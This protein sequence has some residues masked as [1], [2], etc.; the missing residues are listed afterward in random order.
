MTTGQYGGLSI[1]LTYCAV[2]N[3]TDRAIRVIANIVAK[4]EVEYFIDKIELIPSDAGR[5]EFLVNGD[6]LYSKKQMGKH[7]EAG[8]IEAL[9]DAYVRDY[10]TKNNITLPNFDD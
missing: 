6:L 9:M 7:A 3:Y 4:R 2:W 8:Q 1:N 10:M 5:F